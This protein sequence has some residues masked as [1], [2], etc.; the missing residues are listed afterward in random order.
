M[1]LDHYDLMAR[2]FL[3]PGPSFFTD[4]RQVVDFLDERYP[5]AAEDAQ[6]FCDHL[7][8]NDLEDMQ[9][10]FTRSFDVQ[11]ITTL[12]VGYVLFGEDYKRG[13]LL[14]NLNQEHAKAQNDCGLELAD[15]LPNLLR[16]I[17]KSSDEEMVRE[18]AVE[19]LAPTLHK[20]IREFNPKRQ[21]ERNRLYQRHYKT[22]IEQSEHRVAVYGHA[23]KALFSIL[24]QDF[25][26]KDETLA[27]HAEHEFLNFIRAEMSVEKLVSE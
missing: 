3:Y 13:K 10:L 2:L 8:Q 21:D 27:L 18:L 20:M 6:F 9:E 1:N 17:A 24:K 25:Q 19:I 22:L 4:V 26:I 16:L 12:D 14:S 5:L 23:L 15:H 7:P 11:A